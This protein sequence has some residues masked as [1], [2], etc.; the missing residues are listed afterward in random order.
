MQNYADRLEPS[1]KCYVV[2]FYGCWWLTML[3]HQRSDGSDAARASSQLYADE[4]RRKIE[5][6]GYDNL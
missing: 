1:D 6:L 3:Y 5:Q 2:I 4:Q